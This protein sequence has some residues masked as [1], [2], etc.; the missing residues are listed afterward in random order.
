MTTQHRWRFERRA[1]KPL[2]SSSTTVR[3]G[4]ASGAGV[5]TVATVE[6]RE[7]R[8]ASTSSTRNLGGVFAAAARQRPTTTEGGAAGDVERRR[9]TTHGSSKF[10]RTVGD[11]AVV[12]E[13]RETT[14]EKTTETTR[15]ARQPK[16]KPTTHEP[17]TK[18][19][20]T[21]RRKATPTTAGA[22]AFEMACEPGRGCA[23]EDLPDGWLDSDAGA[24]VT[25]AFRRRCEKDVKADDDDDDAGGCCLGVLSRDCVRCGLEIWFG[26]SSNFR[27]V[28][29]SEKKKARAAAKKFTLADDVVCQDADD[30]DAQN[31]VQT[32]VVGFAVYF[33]D[34]DEAYFL[35]RDDQV[36]KDCLTKLFATRRVSTY[37]AQSV[38]RAAMDAGAAID[39]STVRVSDCRLDA[40]LINPDSGFDGGLDEVA[41]VFR[42]SSPRDASD[43]LARLL[44]DVRDALDFCVQGANKHRH[45]AAAR[46]VESRV[47]AG[48]GV[49]EH[50]GIGFDRDR[51]GE[52]K[53]AA[54]ARMDVLNAKAKSDFGVDINLASAQ[55]VADVLFN[56]LALPHPGATHAAKGSKT[57][58]MSTSVE[59]LTSLA[60]RH[61]FPRL[62]LDYRG[63]L[64][65]RAMC[66]GYDRSASAHGD[67]DDE[68]RIHTQWNNTKTAT[69]R[70]SSS[71][72]NVQQVGRGSMRN[73]FVPAPGKTFLAADYSQI[74]L[75][76]L[77]HLCGEEKLI[78][79]FKKA[80]DEGGDVFVAIWNAGKNLPPDAP[81]E[82][83]T[84]DIAKRT[85]YGILYGQHAAG[86]ASK[87]NIGKDEARGYID[88]F[89]RAFPR[90]QTW[91]ARVLEQAAKQGAV[92]LPMSGRHRALPKI[93]SK[94]FGERSEAQR[95]AVNSVIQGTAADMMK[96]AMI[97]WFAAVGRA[98]FA[99]D[100]AARSVDS[101]RIRL[102]A[103]I[104]DELLFEVDE[105]Y[106]DEASDAIRLCMERAVTLS[107]P[108]P[109][110][111]A[112]GP[113]WGEL[114]E[115]RR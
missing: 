8:D 73:A 7:R 12:V 86:L 14:I 13:V 20:K 93:H 92:V 26:Y 96:M 29:A 94:N 59:V 15:A 102:V 82:P 70:L 55:Q 3:D 97:R 72:P 31:G 75:R 41:S 22:E 50:Y 91:I 43:A 61:P 5:T 112:V 1:P 28:E 80:T 11:D 37:H 89:H 23:L 2:A 66:D 56:K 51:A 32:D 87:L 108:C 81:A 45:I 79:M 90:V 33:R 10:D 85:A 4:R 6:R 113:S 76:V 106:V 78:S 99:P 44:D 100:V 57:S 17:K 35:R 36:T 34:G 110:K 67:H 19:A 101:A 65:E 16:S 47:A 111:I 38:V 40:W 71:S 98:E 68:Y 88:A 69:G 105:S 63:A 18:R 25:E 83:G 95:Q 74:E 114:E 62:V 103:Q 84:R 53:D 52:M 27:D 39:P 30:D 21:T 58:H 48:L 109:V 46:R 64:K 104:H 60:E 54:S 24:S 9:T 49:L 42:R 107:V 115:R 77:A